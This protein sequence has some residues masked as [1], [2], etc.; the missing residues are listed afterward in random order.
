MIYF[1]YG[2]DSY[3]SKRKLEEIVD[4]YKKVH[5]SGLNLIYIDAQE[6]DFKD[7]YSNF[8]VSSM[9][10][11]KKLIVLKNMLS[12]DKFCED[13]LEN[14]KKLE[15][16]KDIVVIYEDKPAD[17]RTK[18]FK[19]LIKQAKCQE[20]SYMQ[21]AVLKKWVAD[22]FEKNKVR[23]NSDALD[24]MVNF[25]RNDLWKMASEV[26]KLSDYRSGSVV[27][28]K[29]V[30]LMVRPNIENDIFKTIEAIASK[31]KKI[32]LSLLQKH[33]D[34]GEDVLR[35]L[36]MIAYQF[37]NLLILKEL[38]DENLAY[39]IIVKKSGLHPFVVQ[40]TAYLCG[41][42][43]MAE[44]KRIYQ[45]IF[46]VDAEIKTGKVEPETALSLLLAEI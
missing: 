20:F 42:F 15:E 28:K 7:F 35:L 44:L 23:I 46:Q 6:K 39:G 5:K 16:I 41:G 9:F 36:A 21:P 14:I 27:E 13:F 24:S 1:I 37:K 11:E 31:N 2:E 19:A 17:Q 29:D 32:A 26:K 40:K 34:D 45:K 8:Q 18:V 12:E 3:R 33:L 22:E 43:S 38:Q 25:V 30:E 4:G 10:A